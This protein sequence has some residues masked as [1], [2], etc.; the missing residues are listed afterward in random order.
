[1]GAEEVVHPLELVTSDT[2]QDIPVL[3]W[4]QDPLQGCWQLK[5]RG[6]NV[7]DLPTDKGG[8][9][10]FAAHTPDQRANTPRPAQQDHCGVIGRHRIRTVMF[11]AMLSSIQCNPVFKRFY[12]HLKAQGKLPKVAIIACMRKLIVV[13]NTLLK[14]EERWCEKTA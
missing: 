4:A 1:M 8:L 5:E 12:E 14:N 10:L 11:M 7:G 13:L 2:M 6:F 9:D 3:V